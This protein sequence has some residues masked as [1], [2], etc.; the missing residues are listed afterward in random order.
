MQ[1]S[2]KILA[3]VIS[4]S[5]AI[6]LLITSYQLYQEYRYQVIINYS[7]FD[8]LAKTNSTSLGQAAWELNE[9]Q[10]NSQLEGLINLDE[11]DYIAVKFQHPEGT[12]TIDRG[13]IPIDSLKKTYELFF[14]NASSGTLTLV[15]D[16]ERIYTFLR[17]E[18]MW[19]FL[20]QSLKTFVA[21]LL[22][23]LMI[24][25]V[26]IKHLKKV[27]E[28]IQNFQVN[29]SNDIVLDRKNHKQGSDELDILVSELNDS[30]RKIVSHTEILEEE[31]ANRTESFK[32]EKENAE[33]AS[34]SKSYFLA[35]MSHEIRTPMNGIIG[36]TEHLLE[37][38]DHSPELKKDLNTIKSCSENLLVIINDV[39]TF[40][41]LNQNQ[42]PIS[43]EVL[44][45]KQILESNIDLVSKLAKEKNLDIKMNYEKLP[46]F[47][48]SDKARLSQVFLN[49]LNNAIK[50]T[51]HGE[52]NITAQMPTNELIQVEVK[53]TGIGISKENLSNIF[54]SFSRVDNYTNSPVEG[55]G[56]GLAISKKICNLMGGD[57]QVSSE[58]G[59]GSSFVFTFKTKIPSNSR[60]EQ[61]SNRSLPSTFPNL[62]VLIAEDNLVNQEVI[63]R[64][65]Q[66]TG[67][68]F[69]IA[70]NGLEAWEKAIKESYDLIIMDMQMPKL[71]GIESTK[72]IK[73][74]GLNRK[75]P[76]VALT[77]NI[78]EEQKE[79]CFKAGMVDFL[80]KPIKKRK[81]IELLQTIDKQRLGNNSKAS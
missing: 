12:K 50:F 24:H 1:L 23:L 48:E 2:R 52:I 28:G 81:I 41:S 26:L 46:D 33:R 47:I 7:K 5:S 20:I 10:I 36:I 68:R 58:L 62:K 77:A 67:V 64:I 73:G 75:T 18:V 15:G 17:S 49:L 34:R 51:E 32:R 76:I 6:T 29:K 43:T 80:T 44:Q 61:S 42:L 19:I 27:I 37:G 65:L 57:I 25:H 55:T 39:L 72:K 3:G 60:K 21:S 35:N 22:I 78:L 63:S 9:L 13:S 11:I 8:I 16:T 66:K 71:N 4:I 59:V 70:N 40:S 31:V 53:D 14:D 30:H 79:E 56:L 54:E 74:E 45:V 38:S 69:A